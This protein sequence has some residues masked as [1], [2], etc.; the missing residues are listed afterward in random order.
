MSYIRLSDNKYPIT[1]DEIR[2]AHP[3]TG[4]PDGPTDSTVRPLGYA[5]VTTA[6]R[7][8]TTVDQVAELNSQPDS[9]NVLQ[10]TTRA[11]TS[12]EVTQHKTSLINEVNTAAE[13]ARNR[14]ITPGSGQAMTY[15]EKVSEARAYQTAT[16]PTATDY[17]VLNA[18]ATATGNT[19]SAQATAVL[20]T[21]SQWKQLAAQIEGE[22]QSG[23]A[24]I[25]ATS[26][27]TAVADAQTA[28]D[29]A[30]KALDAI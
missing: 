10:W 21:Y 20:S 11:L 16:N 15:Q 3:T 17:P 7:P 22:R 23:N 13:N 9:N 4:I 2:Q 14:Y 30:V 1:L 25:Q 12:A 26:G 24:K 5:V 8:S 28:K 29:A 27:T 6:T 18:E 19:I